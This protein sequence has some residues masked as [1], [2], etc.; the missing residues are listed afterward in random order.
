MQQPIA[1]QSPGGEIHYCKDNNHEDDNHEDNNKDK[2]NNRGEYLVI[3]VDVENNILLNRYENVVRFVCVY[4][5]IKN[6]MFFINS[7]N[8]NIYYICS[9]LTSSLCL[10]STYNNNRFGIMLYI[11]YNYFTLS[12]YIIEI[13]LLKE[14]Y[15]TNT[16]NTV[17]IVNTVNTVNITNTTNNNYYIDKTINII[18]I[19][20]IVLSVNFLF[21]IVIIVILLKYYKMKNI[22][23]NILY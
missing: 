17:N 4:D 9:T 8:Q 12:I 11:I 19:R 23:N 10:V 1:I 14:F 20:E 6:Y 13:I 15:I 22:N 3:V 16:T 2:N 18:S 21:E 5:I 7:I